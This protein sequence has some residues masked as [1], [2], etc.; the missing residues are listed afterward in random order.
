MT[1]VGC[2]MKLSFLVM[3]GFI[4]DLFALGS[5]LTFVLS[6]SRYVLGSS[7]SFVLFVFFGKDF[8]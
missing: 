3:L 5:R 1:G 8:F 2:A 4:Y 6:F 7:V